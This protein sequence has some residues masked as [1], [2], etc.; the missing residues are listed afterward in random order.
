MYGI[1]L[2]F[3]LG[4]QNM[5]NLHD[6]N[7]KIRDILRELNDFLSSYKVFYEGYLILHSDQSDHIISYNY[8]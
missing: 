7:S 2:Y 6:L 8:I 3:A 4:H 5:H 1:A